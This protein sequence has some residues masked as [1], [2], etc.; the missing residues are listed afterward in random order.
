MGTVATRAIMMIGALLGPSV[1]AQP[2]A[3]PACR[4]PVAAVRVDSARPDPL[5]RATFDSAVA[6]IARTHFDSTFNGVPWR[7]L[8]DSLRPGVV[9]AERRETTRRAIRT[10]LDRLRQSHFA[11]LDEEPAATADDRSARGDGLEIGVDVRLVEGRLV[12]SH[13]EPAGPAADAGLRPGMA[14]VAVNGCPVAP[15]LSALERTTAAALVPV[16]A[17][18][19]GHSLL[20]ARD[21][22]ALEITVD[23][24][25]TTPALAT[26]A[27]RPAHLPRRF[28]V[29]GGLGA[30]PY[31]ITTREQVVDG[32]RIGVLR[33]SPWVT[34]VVAPIDSAIDRFRAADG[35]IIDLRGNGGGIGG[36]VMGIGGHFL[37][38][39]VT[40][41]TMRQRGATLRFMTNPRR[42]SVT[43]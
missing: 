33:F 23:S 29:M 1:R 7:A 39:V 32:V 19:M 27:V 10:M 3:L 35:I 26:V 12:L 17:V 20:T 30:V 41:G 14:L 8:A 11:L 36:L 24:G 37:D 25:R 22:A 28:A 13:V 31:S 5:A 9:A 16:R 43:G 38:S 42:V 2:A 4:T 40:L 34:A 15:A 18:G 6:I 21:T